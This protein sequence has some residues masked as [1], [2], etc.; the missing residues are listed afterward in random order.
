MDL[1]ACSQQRDIGHELIN[2]AIGDGIFQAGL[3]LDKTVDGVVHGVAVL[4]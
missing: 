3:Q 2:G 1:Y 4:H